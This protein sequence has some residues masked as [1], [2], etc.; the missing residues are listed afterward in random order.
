MGVCV[1]PQHSAEMAARLGGRGSWLRPRAREVDTDGGGEPGLA[2][3]LE[4]SPPLSLLP[5]LGPLSCLPPQ[6]AAGDG[7]RIPL[8]AFFH[9]GAFLCSKSPLMPPLSRN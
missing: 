8:I 9:R 7:I 4:A 6:P 1:V 5:L 3:V 2:S